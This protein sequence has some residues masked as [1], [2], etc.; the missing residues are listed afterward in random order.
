MGYRPRFVMVEH[1][2]INKAL[3][4]HAG[5]ID[6]WHYK[7]LVHIFYEWTDIF[8]Q[9]FGLEIDTPALQIDNIRAFGT[10]HY[11]RNGFGLRHEIT[12]NQKSLILSLAQIL[13]ILFHELL[14]E[15]QDLHGKAGKGGY[16]N[17]AFRKK[18]RSFGIVIDERG[19]H[20][21]ILPGAFRDILARY[22][23]DDSAIPLP[24]DEPIRINQTGSSK[25]QK[26]SCGCTNIRAAV[27]LEARCLKCDQKFRKAPT[28]W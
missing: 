11:G 17:K 22:N 15:W 6:D 16:H 21:G 5:S 19:R 12:I 9:E 27:E 7:E 4:D 24:K 8:N 25:M 14:H 13:E 28:A 10:Y 1:E 18:A 3:K 20:L 2:S 26:W 23:V